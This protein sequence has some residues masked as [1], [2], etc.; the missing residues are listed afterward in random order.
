MGPLDRTTCLTR[1]RRRDPLK[2]F[3]TT[4]VVDNC[5][6]NLRASG[7]SAPMA[8]LSIDCLISRQRLTLA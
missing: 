6:H 3:F 5:V 7:E 8:G 4:A 1:R 2:Y